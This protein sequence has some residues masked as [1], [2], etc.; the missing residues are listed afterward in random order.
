MPIPPIPQPESDCFR[1]Y[2]IV[3]G[4]GGVNAE[5]QRWRNVEASVGLNYINK[6]SSVSKSSR[7]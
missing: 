5:D 2:T 7:H 6:L 1:A 4:G 3:V